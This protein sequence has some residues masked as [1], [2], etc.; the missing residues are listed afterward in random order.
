MAVTDKTKIV[1]IDK[2]DGMDNIPVDVASI[3]GDIATETT[4]SGIKT[5]IENSGVGKTPISKHDKQTTAQTDKALWTPSSGKKFV[6]TDI[7]ISVDTA[8]TVT[9][10]DG[11]EEK[12]E[13]YLAANG[14]VVI[15]LKTPY[16]STAADNVLT[17]SSSAA[18]TVSIT[19]L[20]WEE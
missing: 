19:V 13:F 2:A 15:N 16:K 11:G 5:D 1:G 6:I 7:I 17:Y 18:G 12:F 20:G 9:L 8:M 10:K 4:L 14:G 3:S